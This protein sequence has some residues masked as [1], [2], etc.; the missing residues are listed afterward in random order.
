MKNAIK[1][2][3]VCFVFILIMLFVWGTVTLVFS[4]VDTTYYDE[5]I[6]K[7]EKY[8]ELPIGDMSFECS[9]FYHI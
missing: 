1:V 3:Y 7:C 6:I 5:M 2:I 9:R 4:V 8:K